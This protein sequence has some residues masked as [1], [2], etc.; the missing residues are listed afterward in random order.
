MYKVYDN[1]GET[2]DRY[3]VVFL[4]GSCLH[5]SYNPNHPCGVVW[6]DDKF[7]PGNDRE[8]PFDDLPDAV[9]E[10]VKNYTN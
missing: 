9:K 5:L 7:V 3:T 1:G 2:L 10:Y 4:D 8:I 6:G